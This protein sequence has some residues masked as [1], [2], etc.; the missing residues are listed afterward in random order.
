[1]IPNLPITPRPCDER[2]GTCGLIMTKTNRRAAVH[3]FMD[4]MLHYTILPL[5]F[6]DSVQ[7]TVPWASNVFPG[8]AT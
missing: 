2:T 7:P 5:L 3:S 8:S 1:M 4:L 6:D